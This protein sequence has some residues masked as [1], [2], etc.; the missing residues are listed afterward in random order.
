MRRLDKDIYHCHFCLSDLC[1]PV[2][3]LKVKVIISKYQH[4][5]Y[6]FQLCWKYGQP[7]L[8][9]SWHLDKGITSGISCDRLLEV[10]LLYSSLHLPQTCNSWL[11]CCYIE[12]KG[13]IWVKLEIYYT[14]WTKSIS[15]LVLQLLTHRGLASV[16][17]RTMTA[18]SRSIKCKKWLITAC[19]HPMTTL[20]HKIRKK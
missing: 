3:H 18:I 20:S 13:C 17:G 1:H 19:L 9:I 10:L 6:Y 11:W 15:F 12:R 7:L 16:P 2:N 5:F 4:L 14:L 8:Q